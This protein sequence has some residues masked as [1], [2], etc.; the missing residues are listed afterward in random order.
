MVVM[1]LLPVSLALAAAFFW[2]FGQVLG[3]LVVRDLNPTTFNAINFSFLA[4]IL[5]LIIIV[6]G[7]SPT[8]APSLALAVM[9]GA[10]GFFTA[11]QIYFYAM[12]RAPAH[13][14][15][16]IANSSSVWTV[17]LALLLLFG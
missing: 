17:F 5:T 16:P 10:F 11:L 6:T 2:V 12:K 1:N 14:V 13:K 4:I 9:S 3:K 15:V 7:F 8:G